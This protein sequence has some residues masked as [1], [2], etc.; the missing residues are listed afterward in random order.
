VTQGRNT[1][2]IDEAHRDVTDPVTFTD[3]FVEVI[4]D[5]HEKVILLVVVSAMFIILNTSYPRRF[6]EGLRKVIDRFLSEDP[7]GNIDERDPLDVVMERHPDWD[8]KILDRIMKDIEGT[9]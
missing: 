3:Q 7:G 9:Q 1:T 6:F 5:T 8:R 4:D 2:V